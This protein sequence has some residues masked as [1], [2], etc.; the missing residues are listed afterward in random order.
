MSKV[1]RC[2]AEKK[3]G[4]D[5]EAVSVLNQLKE[6][7]GIDALTGVRILHRY[8]VEGI[9]A[10]VYE[11]ARVIVFSEPQVDAVYDETVDA[12]AGAVLAVEALPGQYD[13][14]AD[15]AAQCIQ[16]MAGGD[17]P[18][19]K[20]ATVYL[21]EGTVS[22]A[23]LEQIKAYLINPVECR[24]A[25][26]DKPETLTMTYPV[27]GDVAV[28]DGFIALDEEGLTAL[29]GQYGLAMD[30]ADLTF[31]QDYFR[32]EEKRDPTIT[33]IRVVDTYWSDHCRHTTFSTHIDDIEIADPMIADTFRAYLEL[34]KEVF[35][36]E[37]AAQRP[38][39]LMDLGTIGTKALKKMGLVPELD[40][41]EEIN[42][43]SIHVPAVVDGKEQDWLLM[44]KNGTGTG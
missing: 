39:T 14:R 17:R 25:S 31:L 37:K 41:S 43:C 26:L 8:D 3:P 1:Y 10:S 22:E 6:Q 15:S 33:E 40:E 36:E 29:L 27:P 7:L 12:D 19:V 34:R 21:L 9:D 28:L 32:D 24:E 5:G 42:A 16:L 11:K 30:L 13:Q 35:G 2:F 18:V 20:C 23:D 44:F 38:I 4:F